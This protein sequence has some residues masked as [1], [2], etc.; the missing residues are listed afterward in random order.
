[1]L[2][3]ALNSSDMLLIVRTYYQNRAYRPKVLVIKAKLRN[4][5]FKQFAHNTSE[6]ES[7]VI[8]FRPFIRAVTISPGYTL[9]LS[10]GDPTYT[11]AQT[12][13]FRSSEQT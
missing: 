12:R 5:Y 1:M 7:I 9:T 10:A 8:F 13:S 3:Q 11:C 2:G 4:K 6:A